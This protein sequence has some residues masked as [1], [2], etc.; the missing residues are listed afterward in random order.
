MTCR[1]TTRDG[2]GGMHVYIP[3]W[4]WDK[5]NKDFPRGY[6]VEIG[7]GFFMP[8]IGAF[9]GECKRARGLRQAA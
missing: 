6:H 3:W 4:L 7:G 1:A 8:Q 9:H 5:K 2:M